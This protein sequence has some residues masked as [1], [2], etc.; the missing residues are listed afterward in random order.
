MREQRQ[1]EGHVVSRVAVAAACAVSF[2]LVSA[3]PPLADIGARLFADPAL[4]ADGT[5]ACASCHRPDYAFADPQAVST[6]VGG[7]RGSRN[8]P[9][10]LDAASRSS[11]TWDGRAT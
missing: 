11:F 5:V 2:S 4:S 8:A 7:K 1:G 6:G 10:L 3:G 9:S